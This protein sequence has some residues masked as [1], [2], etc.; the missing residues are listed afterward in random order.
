MVRGRVKVIRVRVWAIRVRT[1]VR[2]TQ[3]R[4]YTH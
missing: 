4:N 3:M 2:V 1:R